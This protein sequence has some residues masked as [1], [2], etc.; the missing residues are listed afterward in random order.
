MIVAALVLLG[1]TAVLPLI[2]AAAPI[3]HRTGPN[4]IAAVATPLA[5]GGVAVLALLADRASGA[6]AVITH[7]LTVLAA[8]TGGTLLVRGALLLGGIEPWQLDTRPPEPETAGSGDVPEP[9]APTPL[10]GGR[11]IGYLERIAVVAALG[12]RW[13]EAIAIVLAVKGLG[14]YPELREPGAAEQFIIGTLASVLWA[15]AVAGTGYLLLH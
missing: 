15:A 6:A 1:V 10:R 4:L 12:L 3:G 2:L 9:P 8:V 11:V 14:R 13:P 5:L 7:C